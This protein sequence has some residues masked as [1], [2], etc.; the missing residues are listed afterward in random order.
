MRGSSI[1]VPRTSFRSVRVSFRS[2]GQE[3]GE[4]VAAAVLGQVR[5]LRCLSRS[6]SVENVRKSRNRALYW[7]GDDRRASKANSGGKWTTEGTDNTGG[8]A[9]ERGGH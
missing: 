2:D 9:K 6:R 3:T 1:D 4:Y 8:K 5:L 7:G